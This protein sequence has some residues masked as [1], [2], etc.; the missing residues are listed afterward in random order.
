MKTITLD[1]SKTLIEQTGRDWY[2]VKQAI[3]RLLPCDNGKIVYIKNGI[4][5]IESKEQMQKR[6][7]T[8]AN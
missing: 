3:G 7:L 1:T 8:P 6:L 5:S 2:A 4:V